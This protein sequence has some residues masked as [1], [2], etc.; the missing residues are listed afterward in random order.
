MHKMSYSKL[1]VNIYLWKYIKREERFFK[2][3]NYSSLSLA[4]QIYS[5]RICLEFSLVV[6]NK[7]DPQTEKRD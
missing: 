4:I 3:S 1:N 6:L 7:N 2:F 5:T